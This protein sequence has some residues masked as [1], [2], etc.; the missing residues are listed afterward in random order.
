MRQGWNKSENANWDLGPRAQLQGTAALGLGETC[1]S[2]QTPTH[3]RWSALR[4]EDLGSF[5]PHFPLWPWKLSLLPACHFILRFFG[6][7]SSYHSFHPPWSWCWHQ[8]GFIAVHGMP[9]SCPK[10]C[11]WVWT[12]PQRLI[13]S[14]NSP[15]GTAY[16]C[17]QKLC[18]VLHPKLTQGFARLWLDKGSRADASCGMKA[19]ILLPF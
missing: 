14:F 17:C 18:K 13:H 10:E 3:W 8:R 15:W 11:G 9:W 4:L 1:P 6:T 19:P 7:G 5:E 12:P 16:T 2:R